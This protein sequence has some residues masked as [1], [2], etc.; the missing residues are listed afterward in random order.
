MQS[1]TSPARGSST[2]RAVSRLLR[3]VWMIRFRGIIR[4]ET[5]DTHRRN[6]P[7]P[8]ETKRQIRF[9]P[10]ILREL[11][12]KPRFCAPVPGVHAT[13]RCVEQSVGT[14]LH[15]NYTTRLCVRVISNLVHMSVVTWPTMT[16]GA[17]P[18]PANHITVWYLGLKISEIWVCQPH[19]P[20]PNIVSWVRC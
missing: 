8:P 12:I 10:G 17:P 7:E 9:H 2:P 6:P 18:K 1:T 11:C 16:E 19:V 4:P 13:G 20:T 5:S 14:I 3:N 15:V